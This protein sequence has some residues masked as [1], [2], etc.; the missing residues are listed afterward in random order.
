MQWLFFVP[1]FMVKFILKIRYKLQTRYRLNVEIGIVSD[2]YPNDPAKIK[3]ATA[4][5]F[6]NEALKNKK[7]ISYMLTRFSWETGKSIAALEKE[8][9]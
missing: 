8:I 2:K 9:S 1:R 3:A 5:W 7:E 4:R 6:Y